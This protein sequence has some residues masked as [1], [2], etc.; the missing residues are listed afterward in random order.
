MVSCREKVFAEDTW[1][2]LN[3]IDDFLKWKEL[4]DDDC[5]W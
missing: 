1:H 4:E 2:Y 5:H 3:W